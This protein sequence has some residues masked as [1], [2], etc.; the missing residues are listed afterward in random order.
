[1]DWFLIAVTVAGFIIL[2]VINVY[3]IVLYQVR[4]SVFELLFAGAVYHVSA[5]LTENYYV[6]V[7]AVEK[8]SGE[9]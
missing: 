5:F 8:I 6:W 7:L 3:L 2:L 4:S 1:M 9:I